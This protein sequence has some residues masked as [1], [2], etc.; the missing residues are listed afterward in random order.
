MV[1]LFL[2]IAYLS[3]GLGIL[4]GIYGLYRLA[5]RACAY[6]AHPKSRLHLSVY[7]RQLRRIG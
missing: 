4:G 6:F 2:L 7:D 5:I 3:I 1:F